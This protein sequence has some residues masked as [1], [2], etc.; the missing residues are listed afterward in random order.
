MA[1][2]LHQLLEQ[3][4]ARTA[5]QTTGQ[6]PTMYDAA[7]A[8]GHAGR[9]LRHMTDFGLNARLDRPR[10]RL[11]HQ[12]SQACHAA[13]RRLWPAPDGE[14]TDLMGAAADIAGRTA[15]QLGRSE[16]WAITVEFAAAADRCATMVQRLVPAAEIVELQLIREHAA[17]VER[18][19]W[20]NP[21]TQAST[22]ALDR[23]LPVSQLQPGMTGTQAAAEAAVALVVAIQRADQRGGLTLREVRAV[24]AGVELSTRYIAGVAAALPEADPAGPWR[25]AGGAWELV[26]RASTT[27]DDLH[28]NPRA[29][30]SDVVAW[31]ARIPQALEHSLGPLPGLAADSLETHRDLPQVLTHVQQVANQTPIIA[32]ELASTVRGWARN[33]ILYAD[34]RHLAQMENMPLDRIADV[35]AGRRVRALPTDLDIITSSIDRAGSLS[36]SLAAELTRA[37]AAGPTPQPHLIELYASRV[38]G[39]RAGEQLL[40]AAHKTEQALT[41]TRTPFRATTTHRPDGPSP[42]R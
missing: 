28:W 35:I 11:I 36:T 24:T 1:T 38:A 20:A 14:L 25:N 6:I 21:P 3:I 32:T 4:S 13:E 30:R 23:L 18:D 5:E 31:A 9:A 40:A 39:P 29:A 42:S 12:L 7:G 37:P 2:S 8:L 27:F 34:A 26:G 15:E 22:T 19:V 41:A 10:E 33:E 17:A 16:R